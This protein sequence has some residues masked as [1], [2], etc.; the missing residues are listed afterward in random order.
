MDIC[1][2]TNCPFYENDEGCINPSAPSPEDCDILPSL[3]KIE[4][5]NIDAPMY[6]RFTYKDEWRHIPVNEVYPAWTEMDIAFAAIT[7]RK[8]HESNGALMVFSTSDSI[9][10]NIWGVFPEN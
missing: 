2:Q 9:D 5:I 4:E 7:F 6:V 3:P 1:H 10:W 8:K